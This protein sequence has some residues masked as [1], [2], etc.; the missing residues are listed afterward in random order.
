MTRSEI[1]PRVFLASTMS[2][3]TGIRSS[4]VVGRV[5]LLSARCGASQQ[6]QAKMRQQKVVTH[7][8]PNQNRVKI[9]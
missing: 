7:A 6:R 8:L 2:T 4:P 9:C 5:I 3:R 1:T